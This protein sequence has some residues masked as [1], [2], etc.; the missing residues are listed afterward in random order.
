VADDFLSGTSGQVVGIRATARAVAADVVAD[1]VAL[2]TLQR[3]RVRRSAARMPTRRRILA[4]AVE[5]EDAPNLLA[6]ARAELERSRHEVTFVSTTTGGRGKFENLNALMVDHPAAGHDWLL[7]LDDDVELPPG[8][9]DTFVFLAE[10]F[11][12]VMAQPAHR[13]RSHAA[14]AVTRRRPR[15]LVRETQFVEIGPVFAFAAPAFAALLPFPDLRAGWGLDA[16]WS[17]VARSH[18]WKL[19][20]VDAVPIRH[21]L[22]QIASSYDRD[23]AL[24]EAR[25]F[26]ADRE[27]VTADEAQR[28]LV[29]HRS[30]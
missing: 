4:L 11:G 21:G 16:Y 30:L 5:R 8:F 19:G 28:T 18:G 24:A 20:V 26:L 17:A 2:G 6:A 10:R 25:S 14:W 12:L 13:Q 1:A 22:R 7:A 3:A 23:A 9:L 27:Y 15:S 29:T